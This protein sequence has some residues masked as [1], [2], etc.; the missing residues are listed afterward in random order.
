MA[1]RVSLTGL[2]STLQMPCSHSVCHACPVC[3]TVPAL[4]CLPCQASPSYVQVSGQAAQMYLALCSFRGMG[5]GHRRRSS[6][7]GDLDRAGSAAQAVPA[8]RSHSRSSSTGA[9]ELQ[10]LRAFGGEAAAPEGSGVPAAVE[11]PPQ[12]VPAGGQGSR[13]PCAAGPLPCCGDS[14]LVLMLSC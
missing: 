6:S 4:L 2:L 8:S 1:T 13:R 9:V 14:R 11:K 5:G 12:A 10:A 7:G 3:S